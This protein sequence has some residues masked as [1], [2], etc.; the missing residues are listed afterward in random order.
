[1]K[2][3]RKKATRDEQA[4]VEERDEGPRMAAVYF[5]WVDAV[6]RR[7]IIRNTPGRYKV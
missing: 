3:R 4:G 2:E 5:L 1:M 6:E 7:G